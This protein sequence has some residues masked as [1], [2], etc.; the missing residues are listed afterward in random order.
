MS[1]IA[2]FLRDTYDYFYLQFSILVESIVNGFHGFF[3]YIYDAVVDTVDSLVVSFSSYFNTFYKYLMSGIVDI[4]E[5]FYLTLVDV[6]ED[7]GFDGDLLDFESVI[8]SI[9]DHLS[10]AS[11][12]LPTYPA[13]GIFTAT[14]IVVAAIRVQRFVLKVLPFVG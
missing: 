9:S 1:W 5:K 12:F 8:L 2:Q 7:Y 11:Y 6:I 3:T 13:A 4:L 10:A 14:F